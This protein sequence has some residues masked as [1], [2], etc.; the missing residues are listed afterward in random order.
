[1]SSDGFAT[2]SE[3]PPLAS[4]PSACEQDNRVRYRPSRKGHVE[5]HFVKA[6]SRDGTRALWIKHTLFVPRGQPDGGLAEV[7]AVAFAEG[8]GRKAAEKRTFPLSAIR[9]EEP[10]A[11]RTPCAEIVQGA[12]RGE[13]GGFAWDLEFGCPERAFRPFPM[14]AMYTGPFPRSKSLTPA[15]DTRIR[16]SFRALGEHWTV[17]GWRAAQGHNWGASHA[18]SYAWAHANAFADARGRELDGVWIE[19]LTGRVR[20]AP[21]LVTPAL[22]VA[23]IALEGRVVRFDGVRA[24]CSR[25]VAFDHRSYQLELTQGGA[26]LRARFEAEAGRFAGLRYEDPDRRMLACLNAKLATGEVTLEEGGR[27]VTLHTT[28]AALELGTRQSD[29]GITLLA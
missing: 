14:A 20:I 23:A 4:A 12:L 5:S 1:M 25:R 19:A 9:I 21:G 22:S 6:T 27:V 29:H 13:L 15:P 16:G 26:R 3:A 7:W 18:E 24:L 28:Q 2:A 8:G 10:F 17:D 11:I